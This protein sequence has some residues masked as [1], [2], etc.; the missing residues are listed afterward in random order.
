MAADFTPKRIGTFEW[1]Q[2]HLQFGLALMNLNRFA[3]S[4][5]AMKETLVEAVHTLG[6]QHYLVGLIWNHLTA[7]YKANGQWNNA[8]D[9]A[10]KAQRIFHL[11]VGDNNQATLATLGDIAVL[12]YLRGQT[13]QALTELETAHA[14]LT[15]F[16]G[17][18]SPF[19]QY[20]D[21]YW[22]SALVDNGQ[23]KNAEKL[24]SSL[25]A[26]ALNAAD[27][28]KDWD[29]RLQGLNGRILLGRHRQEDARAAL[30]IAVKTLL[31]HGAQP[32]V[33]A[34]LRRALLQASDATSSAAVQ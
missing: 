6:P 29:I 34:P 8:L 19:T 3:E 16:V 31:Q 14:A 5:R 7:V 25:D 22:A 27:P 18:T 28:V 24:F 30:Q 12:D 15:Q 33:I 4:E 11:A 13:T 26:A 1:V 21:F 10:Q 20:I 17:V 2:L 9:A 32:W 23:M